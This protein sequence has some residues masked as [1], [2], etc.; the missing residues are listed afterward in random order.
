MTMF[1]GQSDRAV[2]RPAL[3]LLLAI[4]PWRQP[5]VS[6]SDTTPQQDMRVVP[7]VAERLTYSSNTDRQHLMLGLCIALDEGHRPPM[8]EAVVRAVI[9]L[10]EDRDPLTRSIAVEVLWRVGDAARPATSALVRVLA[11]RDGSAGLVAVAVLANLGEASVQP[12]TDAL[13][14]KDVIVRQLAATALGR[15]GP[16]AKGA[17][18]ALY[19]ARE[20]AQEDVVRQRVDIAIKRILRHE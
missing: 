2:V 11:D 6:G 19:K 7:V 15:I 5:M 20:A 10:V 13:G 12:L 16:R 9:P 1:Q 8:I 14:Q 3:L 4:L 17:L 18:P